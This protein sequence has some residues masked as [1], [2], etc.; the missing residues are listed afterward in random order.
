MAM[1]NTCKM[2]LG[3]RI[4][5]NSLLRHFARIK[6][7][8]YVLFY[9]ILLTAI[10]CGDEQPNTIDPYAENKTVEVAPDEFK[11]TFS[12][13][14]ELHGDL[15]GTEQE[16]F[17]QLEESG[18]TGTE[19]TWVFADHL[20]FAPASSEIDLI[21]S[22]EQLVNLAAILEAFPTTKLHVGGFVNQTEATDQQVAVSQQ[23]AQVVVNSLM[24]LGI[25]VTRLDAKGYGAEDPSTSRPTD[26]VIGILLRAS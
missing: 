24:E 1:N 9:P 11:H 6:R 26:Q 14:T 2:K 16:L 22:K 15:N 5:I 10:A 12:D 8:R 25:P 23:R 21:R 17:Q 19:G 18:T 20:F 7:K 4:K 3:R 13:G